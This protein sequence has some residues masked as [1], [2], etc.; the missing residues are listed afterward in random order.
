MIRLI[1]TIGG[2]FFCGVVIW[3]IENIPKGD[4][5]R[6]AL[7]RLGTVLSILAFSTALFWKKL[8]E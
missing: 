6:T 5:L 2:L 8:T 3:S 1:I 7:V 4:N